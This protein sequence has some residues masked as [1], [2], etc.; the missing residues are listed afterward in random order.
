[1]IS[2]LL[3]INR[4]YSV[5]A[6]KLILTAIIKYADEK[7]FKTLGWMVERTTNNGSFSLTHDEATAM[8][9]KIHDARLRGIFAIDYSLCAVQCQFE[10]V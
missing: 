10:A 8:E 4:H 2:T 1:M 3:K 6:S 5:A 9:I 7:A